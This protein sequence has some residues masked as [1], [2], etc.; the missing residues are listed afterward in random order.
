MIPQVL[1]A[2]EEG[3]GDMEVLDAQFEMAK[4]L[5]KI[6]DKVRVSN[7]YGLILI[8]LAEKKNTRRE[9][10]AHT[11]KR[12]RT[13]NLVCVMQEKVCTGCSHFVLRWKLLSRVC[14][15][16]CTYLPPPRGGSNVKC[17]AEEKCLRC[18]RRR[19][20]SI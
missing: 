4:M 20:R 10:G 1:K 11:L 16:V 2:A 18:S 17:R 15:A 3:E 7:F 13:Q 19:S 12:V 8:S 6:G 5:A 9:K 14:V